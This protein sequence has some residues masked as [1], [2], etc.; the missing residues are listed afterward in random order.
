MTDDMSASDFKIFFASRCCNAS[1][2]DST[3][4]PI[5]IFKHAL[6]KTVHESVE[7]LITVIPK[8]V[9]GKQIQGFEFYLFRKAAKRSVWLHLTCF[10]FDFCSSELKIHCSASDI[11]FR[12][13][14]GSNL[15]LVSKLC[16]LGHLTNSDACRL[17]RKDARGCWTADSSM[18]FQ[19]L[20][21]AFRRARSTFRCKAE[22]SSSAALEQRHGDDKE[23]QDD[24]TG[25][26]RTGD[27][28]SAGGSPSLCSMGESVSVE[29]EEDETWRGVPQLA[30]STPEST[31]SDRGLI[32]MSKVGPRASKVLFWSSCGCGDVMASF[33]HVSMRFPKLLYRFIPRNVPRLSSPAE[34]HKEKGTG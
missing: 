21:T 13:T 16:D 12:G 32:P 33:T 28:D 20:E 17:G 8:P 5:N 2:K 27:W 14:D 23:E 19:F 26:E 15:L 4:L 7:S 6:C 30:N 25:E 10:T 22:G 1:N 18:L 9:W 29:A 34:L 3:R 24:G 11:C 31:D